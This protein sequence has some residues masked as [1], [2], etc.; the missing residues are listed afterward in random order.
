MYLRPAAA[1]ALVGWYLMIPPIVPLS[2]REGTADANAPL[3][4]WVKVI[5]GTFDSDD[6]CDVALRRFQFAVQS[7][8]QSA[9]PEALSES[10]FQRIQQAS[11]AKCIASDDLRLKE[12]K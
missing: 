6:A 1:L 2:G 3:S 12:T 11:S 5:R 9:A 8:D 10:E 7:N 4:K